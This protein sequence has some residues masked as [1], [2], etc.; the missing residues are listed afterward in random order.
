MKITGVMVQY[1]IACKR[2]LWFF[3]NQINMNY[4]SD[5]IN[6]GRHIH[7]KS[8]SR[9]KKNIN[10][11]DIAFDFIKTGDKDVIFE[12]KKSSKLEEPVRF[13]LYYYLWNA[14]KMGKDMEGM[15]VYPKEKKR[16]RLILTP[17]IEEEVEKIINDIPSIVS[18]PYPP[19]VIIKPY[20]KRCTYYEL[21]M[22]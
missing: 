5:D 9:E 21:C 7:E 22:V 16:E 3:A 14:K 17:Q 18:Q 15:L 11:G 2:E 8:Y 20:C 12:I 1:Y 6:I 10:L 13:Q 4:N 19:P